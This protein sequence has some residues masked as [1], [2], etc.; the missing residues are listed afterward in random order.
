[1]KGT[2][3]SKLVTTDL[4]RTDSIAYP[5]VGQLKVR[6]LTSLESKDPNIIFHHMSVL[7]FT[8]DFAK[9]RGKW[10]PVHI[11]LKTETDQSVPESRSR[12]TVGEEKEWEPDSVKEVADSV[13][14]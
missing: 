14:N 8:M 6:E 5:V 4:K 2:Y 1:M 3:S 7:L 13:Q 12:S 11:L 10:K 9:V